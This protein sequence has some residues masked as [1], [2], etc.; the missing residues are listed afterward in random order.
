MRVSLVAH[1]VRFCLHCRKPRFNPWVRRIPWR[2][3]I[4]LH[5]H[6]YMKCHI[7]IFYLFIY[8]LFFKF[9]FIFKLYIIVLVLPNIKMNPPQVYMCSPSWT[10]WLQAYI[11]HDWWKMQLQL[12]FVVVVVL[13]LFFLHKVSPEWKSIQNMG[14]YDCCWYVHCPSLDYF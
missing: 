5:K 12:I 4:L 9:Y 11:P 14:Y 3:W 10:L 7:G 8:Y 1:T 13:G 2:E 6:V